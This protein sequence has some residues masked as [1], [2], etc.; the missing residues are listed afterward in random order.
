MSKGQ[1][2]ESKSR[3]ERETGSGK[4]LRWRRLGQEKATEWRNLSEAAEAV[5][6][7]ERD[8]R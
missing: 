5:M 7:R 2:V 6:L 3:E 1:E 4:N 8:E